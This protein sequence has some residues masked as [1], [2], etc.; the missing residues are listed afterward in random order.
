MNYDRP[1]LRDFKHGTPYVSIWYS[2]VIHAILFITAL[3]LAKLDLGKL[4][5]EYKEDLK[6]IIS[7]ILEKKLSPEDSMIN[8][9]FKE[10][11]KLSLDKKNIL[12]QK[13]DS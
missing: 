9:L 3:N 7:G 13:S 6:G 8:E 12:T 5:N 10:K 11:Y 1:K 2:I 4:A